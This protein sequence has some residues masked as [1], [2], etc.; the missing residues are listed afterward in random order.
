[1][2]KFFL[3][4]LKLI[5]AGTF[6]LTGSYGTYA[7]FLGG[8]ADGHSDLQLIVSV[9]SPTSVN[10][11][12]GGISD[13]HSDVFL[14]NTVCSVTGVNP[15]TGGSSD[16][17]SDVSLVNS[18]CSVTG[19]NPLAGGL[20]EGHS[21]LQTVV[22]SCAALPIELLS[23]YGNNQGKINMLYWT[24]ASQ[25]NNDYF[26]LEHSV[27]AQNFDGIGTVNG[28]GT[29]SQKMSYS[30]PDNNPYPITYYRLK[31]TDFDG[32][33]TYSQM[34]SIAINSIDIISIYPNP[35]STTISYII[36][37]MEDTQV[38]IDLIDVLGRS[39]V[40]QTQSVLQGINN[41]SLSVSNLS[42][43]SYLLMAK[44]STGSYR[45]QKQVVVR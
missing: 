43:G 17:H 14:I 11:S 8:G 37:S 34:I 45:I 32:K 33:F 44:T 39:I 35:S 13:G 9:C 20:G 15:S 38:K 28:A 7:Q 19:V 27:D 3:N 42:D 10:P 4:Y 16:G 22:V 29:S 31:Q 40:T 25:T 6:L 30:L 24:T 21:A 23:F 1:M 5:S 18:I 12:T 26:T 2:I 36:S 41:F